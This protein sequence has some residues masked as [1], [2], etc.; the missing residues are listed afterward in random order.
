MNNDFQLVEAATMGNKKALEHLLMSVRDK[1]YNLCLRFLWQPVDAEDATQEILIRIIT[2]LNSFKGN[3]AFSTWC[4]RIAVNYLLNKKKNKLEQSFSSFQVFAEDLE[5]GLDMAGYESA[6]KLLLEQE[7]KIGCTQ[8]MLLCLSRDLRLAFVLG[9]VF[10]LK[11]DEAAYIL[12]ITAENFRKRL[13]LSRK[14]LNT[15]MNANCGLVNV[16]C[17]CRCAKRINYALQEKRI[18]KNNLLFVKEIQPYIT[19]MEE[20]HEMAAIYKSDQQYPSLLQVTDFIDKL[21][22]EGSY[23]VL[24]TF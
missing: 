11:S 19:E 5:K 24:G 15:F 7:V 6:D 10:E 9:T 23:K 17:K 12:D 18:D 4:Y 8:G 14:E 13:S 3:S 1:V 20:L 2:N 16:A 21:I 22:R